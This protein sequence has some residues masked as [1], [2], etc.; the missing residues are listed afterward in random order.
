M[1]KKRT[2]ALSIAAA[3]L[4]LILGAVLFWHHFSDYSSV[5]KINWGF[6]LPRESH[7]SDIYNQ[8]SDATFT[9]DGI[10]YHVFSCEDIDPINKLFA[11]QSEEQ[12]TIYHS[13]YTAACDEWL[14]KINVPVQARPDYEN[15]LY[16]Y[17]SQEDNSEIII[18]G[19][20]DQSKLYVIELFV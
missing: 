17:Q 19:D 18:F 16:W 20:E 1:A 13:S 12:D 11:W 8:R 15:C 3:I 7:Y 9:G 14:S 4:V 6:S 5:L 10:R 2:I